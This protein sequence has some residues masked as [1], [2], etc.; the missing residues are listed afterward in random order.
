MLTIPY[1]LINM[2]FFYTAFLR[3]LQI[4]RRPRCLHLQLQ[5]VIGSSNKH[6]VSGAIAPLIICL[7][8]A[9]SISC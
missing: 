2:G 3:K 4:I 8:K 9:V 5:C 1:P 7:D 6:I